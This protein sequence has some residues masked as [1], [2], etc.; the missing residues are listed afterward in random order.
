VTLAFVRH[1]QTNWN[2][3]GLF[4]GSSDIPLNET[5][6]AQARE[7]ETMLAQ[8]SW[9]AIVSSPLSRA[10]ETARIVA[11][12]L[13]LP[14]G[15]AY[16][17]LVERDYGP[18][19]GTPASVGMER[20]PDRRYPGAEPLDEV[21]ERCLRGL[22]RIDDDF[23]GQN[24]VVVCHGTIIKYTLIRLTGH[25]IDYVL[26]GTVSA[27]ERDG[28]GWRVLSVNGELVAA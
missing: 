24:V 11:E 9:D 22:A 4:Q 19:E 21:V 13:K 2:A 27:M 12:H 15:P 17:E 8:W 20:W 1:G 14:L 16:D 26:N 3:R 25:P 7:A 6:R 28:D 23:P 18:L 5:G 10:R